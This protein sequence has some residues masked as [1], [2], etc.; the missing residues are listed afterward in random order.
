MAANQQPIMSQPK[1][2]RAKMRNKKSASSAK[3][4]DKF[5]FFRDNQ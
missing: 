3:S 5:I 1:K 4:A 2:A